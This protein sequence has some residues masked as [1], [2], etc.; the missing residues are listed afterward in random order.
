[1][2]SV[3]DCERPPKMVGFTVIVTN[4]IRHGYRIDFYMCVKFM[5]KKLNGIKKNMCEENCNH[6]WAGRDINIVIKLLLL[7]TTIGGNIGIEITHFY[8]RYTYETHI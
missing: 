3:G 2:T 4:F 7:K 1:M 8:C 6:Y 5:E